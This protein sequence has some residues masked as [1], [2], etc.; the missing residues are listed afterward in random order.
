MKDSKIKT[1]FQEAIANF[2]F[3]KTKPG[4]DWFSVKKYGSGDKDKV[5]TSYVSQNNGNPGNKNKEQQIE[6]LK[7]LTA[8]RGTAPDYTS[9]KEDQNLDYVKFTPNNPE[10]KPGKNLHIINFWGLGE[11]YEINF[12]DMAKETV[13]TGATVYGFN[14][15]G[16]NCSGGKTRSFE[17]L[18]NSGVNMVNHLISKGVDP[19]QIVLQGNCFGAAV[20]E[21]LK[22]HLARQ[23]VYMR[24]INSNS[25]KSFNSAVKDAAKNKPFLSPLRKLSKAI[26]KLAGWDIKVSE[27]VQNQGP[28]TLIM[29]RE[30]DATL[31]KNTFLSNNI[32]SDN[33]K[34]KQLEGKISETKNDKKKKALE[35][36]KGKLEHEKENE[37]I[38]TLNTEWVGETELKNPIILQKNKF[39]T[40]KDKNP[41]EF[42]IY[43]LENGFETIN[44]FLKQSNEQLG[45]KVVA[46]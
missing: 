31:S 37:F 13:A 16:I 28:Y 1:Y 25:F 15:P 12:R 41:H 6:E 44:Q 2:F 30:G 24:S 21:H 10:K 3:P 33:N 5:L 46:S 36:R 14:Y 23:G 19:K 38:K 29:N 45:I 35:E 4:K 34:I 20:A 43:K 17:D 32:G 8:T 39:A 42:D 9:G 7:Y 27:I 26:I 11:C 40:E 22:L 18:V